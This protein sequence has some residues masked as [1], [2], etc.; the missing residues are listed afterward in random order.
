V[1]RAGFTDVLVTGI[2]IKWIKVSPQADG[3]RREAGRSAD[4]ASSP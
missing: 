4:C 1:L 2:E 3:H